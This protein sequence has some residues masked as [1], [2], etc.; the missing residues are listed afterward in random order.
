[1]TG[2]L[3]ALRRS[4]GSA[5]AEMS[6]E[7]LLAACAVGEIA[8]LGGLFDRHRTYVRRFIG[9]L[10]GSDE[11]DLDD[12]VQSTFLELYRS[13]SRFRGEAAVRS[14]ILGIANNVVRTHARGA[15]RRRTAMS[16]LASIPQTLVPAVDGPLLVAEQM[17]RLRV[18][19]SELTHDR[20][21]AFV[22]CDVEEV[23]GV[24]AA[25][26]LGIRTGTLGR[27]LHEAR[28]ALRAALAE[29]HS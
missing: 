14:W 20:R 11:R 15:I 7:A 12:L 6:D 3:I 24:E 17:A 4:A 19:M 5:P 22:M 26:I 29:D 18:A 1:M 23:P 27:R 21:V 16:T 10:A 9:Q 25:R 2:K 13:A 8:A 28:Q